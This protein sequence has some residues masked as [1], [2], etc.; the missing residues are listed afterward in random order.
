MRH[1]C[2]VSGTRADFGLM[3]RTLSAIQAHPELSLSLLVTGMHL[4]PAHG[5]TVD[6]IERA[7][8]TIAARVPVPTE[9]ATGAT[10]ARNIGTMTGAFAEALEAGRPDVVLLLGDRGEMLAGAL[11]A[12][13]LNI[14]VAHVC[15]GE[16]SGTIDEPVRHAI[17]KLSHLHFAATEGAA[18]RL[19]KMGEAPEH[20]H[21]VGAPGV[22]GLEDDP[23]AG[24]AAVA[25]RHSLDPDRPIALFVYHPV[26]Q[27]AARAESDTALLVEA[28]LAAGCQIIALMP[29]SDAGSDGVR[30]AL[31]AVTTHRDIRVLTH[32]PREAFL[33]ALAAADIMVGNSSSG[34][35]EAASFGTPVLNVGRRQNLRE[36][37]ANLTDVAAEPDE[38]R[39]GLARLLAGGRLPRANIYSIAGGTAAGRIAALLA[40]A[41]LDER[42]LMK[43]NR[44]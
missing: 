37:N 19:V 10:M 36:R 24:R 21:V 35:T 41:P 34:I 43:V 29:N 6:E 20:V 22:D 9:P 42:L 23:R 18:E 17:S 7:G 32:L 2:Y 28:L 25:E 30:R 44:Y 31:D 39:E 38:V 12:I 40:T 5:H 13:H 27:E 26:L 1:V 4:A 33:D 3:S 14:P 15:G 8:L 11:A 16:R